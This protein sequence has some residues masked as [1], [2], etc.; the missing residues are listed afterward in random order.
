M[1]IRFS[2]ARNEINPGFFKRIDNLCR[3][4]PFHVSSWE[5]RH[6]SLSFNTE[7]SGFL[8]EAEALKKSKHN[9]N[10]FPAKNISSSGFSLHKGSSGNFHRDQAKCWIARFDGLF[11]APGFSRLLSAV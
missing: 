1:Q 4:F 2:Q 7:A 5:A 11:R 8:Q 9:R 10:R 3:D 6:R